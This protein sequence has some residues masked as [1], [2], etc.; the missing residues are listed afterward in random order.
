MGQCVL[1]DILKKKCKKKFNII[2]ASYNIIYKTYLDEEMKNNPM[3]NIYHTLAYGDFLAI[4]NDAIKEEPN[5][6]N[7]FAISA[8]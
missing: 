8:E 2:D 7:A 3:K 4:F 5:M 6:M 1:K